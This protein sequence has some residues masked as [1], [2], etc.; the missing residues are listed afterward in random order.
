MNNASA[1]VSGPAGI[2]A[3]VIVWFGQL[4][5]MLSTQM[6]QF[7]LTVWSFEKTSSVTA[8]ALTQVFFITPFLLISPLAGAMIDKYNRK[9]M[10][11]L[12]DLGSVTATG[13]VLA[14]ALAGQL[15]IWHLYIAAAVNGLFNSFQWPAF[16]ASISLMVPKEQLG[17][18][19]G[20]MSLMEDGPSVLAPLLAGTL[21]PLIGL[22]GMLT[23]DFAT[24]FVAIAALA[25]VHI[26]QPPSSAAGPAKAGIL[27]EAVF[28]F[29]HIFQRP[30]L[31]GLQLVFFSCNL[32]FGLINT[33]LAPSVLART[34][35]NELT[36]GAVQT[37][38]A[39]GAIAGGLAMTA[40][41]GF[42]RRVHGVLLGWMISGLGAALVGFGQQLW[43]WIPAMLL[44]SFV[45]PLV[46][47][48]NQSIWQ[49]KV[50]PDVQGRV[51]TARRLIAWL[52]NPISPLIAGAL[53]D[54]WLEPAMR[55]PESSL[56]LMFGPLFG[57]GPGAGMGILMALA[58]A[59]C[60][61][62]GLGGYSIGAVRNAETR[63]PDHNA[64][65]LR[66]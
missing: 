44:M 2:R 27:S 19:N 20:M 28:G 17:R 6:S 11:M 37:A 63:L 34:G 64:V 58:G 13:F 30:S 41:G 8:L 65:P 33:T 62:I 12:S 49:S 9:L 43:A 10:M 59:A 46:N 50:A 32:F 18:V 4:L 40:W 22:T 31:L 47:A 45:R 60:I 56:A 26:P 3:F 16:S 39:V 52:A 51:F 5:S 23:L 7:A 36:L 25:L 53:A 14:M 38:G 48:S 42:K 55:S 15:E 61:L 21:Y 24:F 35:N 54:R 66:P 1:P 29:R 57:V